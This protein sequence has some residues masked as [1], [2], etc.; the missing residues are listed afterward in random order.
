MY[1]LK[2][3]KG[4][5]LEKWSTYSEAQQVLMI[6][7]ELNR[8]KNFI[9][10]GNVEAVN[11][12]YERAFEITDLTSSDSKWKGKRRELRRFRELLAEQYVAS[13]KDAHINQLLFL[14]LLRLSPEAYRTLYPAEQN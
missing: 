14:G 7:N 5:T 3:H 10:A 13:T 9:A 4:L 1:D 6:S 2:L 12:C 11:M 8:A